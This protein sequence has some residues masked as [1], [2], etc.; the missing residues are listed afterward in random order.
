MRKLFLYAPGN[1]LGLRKQERKILRL[2]EDL[3]KFVRKSRGPAAFDYIHILSQTESEQ[4]DRNTCAERGRSD[5]GVREWRRG[6][7]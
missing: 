1:P 3:D 7:Q 2:G 6:R 5:G 4:V